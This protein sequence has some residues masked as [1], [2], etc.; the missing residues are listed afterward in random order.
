MQQ[1]MPRKVPLSGRNRGFSC[2]YDT[3]VGRRASWCSSPVPGFYKS[4]VVL[5]L[6]PSL[7]RLGA[8]DPLPASGRLF[9]QVARS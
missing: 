6:A 7:P 1:C 2:L 5:S 4:P 8:A 3:A 9:R